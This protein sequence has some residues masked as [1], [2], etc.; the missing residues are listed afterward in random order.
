M[1]LGPGA[2]LPAC[3]RRR[4]ADVA[5]AL[6]LAGMITALFAIPL[7]GALLVSVAPQHRARTVALAFTFL[8]AL[9]TLTLW[10]NFNSSAG[11]LQFVER[12]IWLPAI[13]AEY[14]L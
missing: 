5:V 8:S 1:A 12:H 2:N 14:L 10:R 13:G 3:C 9:L 7:V 4:Y 6:R 11:G